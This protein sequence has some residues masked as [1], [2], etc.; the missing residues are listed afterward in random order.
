MN[1]YRYDKAFLEKCI[2]RIVNQYNTH[3][4]PQKVKLKFD[5]KSD[6]GAFIRDLFHPYGSLITHPCKIVI[7]MKSVN[8]SINTKISNKL[9]IDAIWQCLHECCHGL[10]YYRKYLLTNPSYLDKRLAEISVISAYFEEY[11]LFGYKNNPVEI[12]ADL[13]AVNKTLEFCD[14]LNLD[15]PYESLI[16]DRINESVFLTNKVSSIEDGISAYE[17][18]LMDSYYEKRMS[19]VEVGLKMIENIGFENHLIQSSKQV[20]QKLSRRYKRFRNDQVL[21]CFIANGDDAEMES[22]Y[23]C[24]YISLK[25]PAYFRSYPS[26]YKEYCSGQKRLNNLL[27]RCVRFILRIK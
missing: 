2:R 24:R 21:Y 13:Y 8:Q 7:G 16:L 18:R 23:L 1:D 26:L 14:S 25:E 17:K 10:Q 12:E 6:D 9:F 3:F 22:T 11:Y 27:E 20:E 19:L 5:T 15:I 4:F